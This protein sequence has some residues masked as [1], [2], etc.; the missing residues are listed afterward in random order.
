M[1]AFSGV[2]TPALHL[3][4]WAV[5]VAAVVA[6]LTAVGWLGHRL[7]RGFRRAW[8]T[9]ASWERRWDALDRLVT[10]ELQPNTGSSMKDALARLEDRQER[11][12]REAALMALS[13][14]SRIR[15][16]ED[17]LQANAEAQA[18]LWP[19]I[20]AV[21]EATPANPHDHTEESQK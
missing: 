4:E 3:Q 6:G 16:V 15:S 2:P 21:A 20:Q 10:H 14:E 18:T 17:A 5:W 11:H 12:M 8:S 19:A 9:W 13:M 7:R 1:A